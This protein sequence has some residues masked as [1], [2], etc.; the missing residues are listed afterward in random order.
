MSNTFGKILTLTTFGESHGP[1]IGGVIDGFPSGLIVDVENINSCLARR[2]P[3]GNAFSTKRLETDEVEFLSGIFNGKTLGTP[4]GFIIRN[5]DQHSHDYV[6]LAECY[7]PSHADYTYDVKYGIRDWRG[8]GRASAR[9][10]VARVV[11]GS[12]AMQALAQKGITIDAYTYQIGNTFVKEINQ[13]K[14][15]PLCCPDHDACMLMSNEIEKARQNGDTLGGIISCLIKGVPAGIGQPIYNKLHQQLGSAMLSINAC[16]GVE[17]GDGFAIS[18]MHGS[19]ANDDFISSNGRIST[20]TNHSGGIQG[21]ISNGEDI[22]FNVAFKP[23]PT[24]MREMSTINSQGETVTSPP[25]GRHDVCF[26]PRAI[27]IV[28]SMAALV[29][30]DHL[31]LSRTTQL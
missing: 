20:R 28:E 10:T 9:E 4:I 31:L 25:K 12:L 15:N 11:A 2:R 26:I 6:P 21:G 16:K 23:V 27:P 29:V 19:E 14:S 24:L 17:F 30:L 8:G 1:A 13:S 18:K 5:T 7:R 3:N 22:I